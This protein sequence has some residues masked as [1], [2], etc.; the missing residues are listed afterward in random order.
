LRK[1][2]E[3]KERLLKD[4]REGLQQSIAHFS[5]SDKAERERWICRAF[6]YNLNF[7][8]W[9]KS[10][11]SVIDDPPDVIYRSASFEVKEIL[12][13]GRK[14]HDEYRASLKK[15]QKATEPSDLM[16]PYFSVEITPQQVGDL[17]FPQLEA[18]KG[19]Y[20][21][22]LISSLDLL[23]YINL[24][25]THLKR[26]DMPP[27]EAFSD[28][29]WRSVSAVFGWWALVFCADSTAPHF[30]RDYAGV[31]SFRQRWYW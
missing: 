13:K 23:F 20:P 18:L 3:W 10:F 8:P 14:R 7:R 24:I 30:I 31:A 22:R 17:L 5:S 21:R 12:D 1:S 9:Q 27:S 2:N 29:G 26:G 25:H 16:E 6:L 15:A 28:F 11:K 19:K 4:M